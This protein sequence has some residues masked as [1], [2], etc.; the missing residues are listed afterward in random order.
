MYVSFAMQ[1]SQ[2]CWRYSEVSSEE[3]DE[4][5]AVDETTRLDNVAK[6]ER[7]GENRGTC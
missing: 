4:V 6:T 3:R 7:C 1:P 5:R 2:S